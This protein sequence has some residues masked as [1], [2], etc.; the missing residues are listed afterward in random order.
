MRLG[1]VANTRRMRELELPTRYYGNACV[2]AMAT[3]TA[4]ALRAGSL[5]DMVELVR[6][7]KALVTAEFVRSTADLFV[8]R[9][10][11]VISP[12]NLLVVSDCRY[13]GFQTVDFGWGEP[14]YCGPMHRH[15][16]VSALL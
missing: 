8:L 9:G 6:E 3:T 5:G 12:A 11:P 10:R 16:P 14:V 13:A 15:E 7:A 2:L 1:I 4:E